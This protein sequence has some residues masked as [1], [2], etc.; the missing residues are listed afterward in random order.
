MLDLMLQG[1]GSSV[2]IKIL[3]TLDGF[4]NIK[5]YRN[6][7]NNR[8]NVSVYQTERIVPFD[9]QFALQN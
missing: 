9:F 7:F 8:E 5:S 1:A 6:L 4:R 3:Q 2:R